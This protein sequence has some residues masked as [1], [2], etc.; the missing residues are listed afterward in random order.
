MRESA[1]RA[2]HTKTNT[3]PGIFRCV[4]VCAA[5]RAVRSGVDGNVHDGEVCD[6]RLPLAGPAATARAACAPKLECACVYVC[7]DGARAHHSS[8]L[9]TR[10]K[11]MEY[12]DVHISMWV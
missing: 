3:A 5:R 8:F 7:I 12:K 10:P 4:C 9:V 1:A 2:M 6:P 11:R